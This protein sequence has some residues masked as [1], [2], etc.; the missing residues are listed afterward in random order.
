[1]PGRCRITLLGGFGV[2]IDGRVVPDSAWRGR[3]SDIVT[4][5]AL[6][7]S[8]Q[9][10]ADPVMERFW[11][12][13]KEKDALRELG[14]AIKDARRAMHDGRAITVEGERLRLW[15]HGELIVDAFTFAAKAKH[16]HNEEQRGE[17]IAMYRGELLPGWPDSSLEALRARLRLTYLELLRDPLS[18]TPA[19]IDLREPLPQILA[20]PL[21]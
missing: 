19:W 12:G 3:S 16:A 18:G 7:P 15:P 21:T 1:M 9:L 13:A 4:L 17:A 8:H 5:L 10:M 6:E 14:T 11:P 20:R 2:E